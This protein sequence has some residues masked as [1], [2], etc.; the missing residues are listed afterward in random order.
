MSG[1]LSDRGFDTVRFRWREGSDAYEYFRRRKDGYQQW[2]ARG[3]IYDQTELGR[4]GV[5]PDGMTY[6]EGR[7]AAIATWNKTNHDLLPPEKIHSAELAAREW[8]RERGALVCKRPATLGRL[9][10]A[11]ELRFSSSDEGGAF[12]HS[13]AALDV[14]WCKSRVDGRKGDHIETVSFHGTRGKTIY[15]RAYDKGVESGSDRPGRRVRVERQKRFRK[16]REPMASQLDVVDLRSW[17]V[18][19][20]FDKFSDLPSA[21]IGDLRSS[22]LAVYERASSVSQAERLAG[23]LVLG[24]LLVDEYSR[25]SLYRR[26]QE[27]RQLGIFVDPAQIE[28]LE[29]PV[30]QY[31]QTL[32]AAWAA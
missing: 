9:D 12:L 21:S 2:G 8:A 14:P 23:Y 3:E 25:P 31:L 27:L 20:E 1:L 32:G 22:L 16:D 17:Y 13:L 29:V 5:F 24:S 10:L 7:A 4:I 18:G 30:G 19:R 11:S 15:L 28:R 26:H 6:L